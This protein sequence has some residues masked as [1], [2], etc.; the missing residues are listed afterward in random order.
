MNLILFDLDHTLLNG[1]TQSEWGCYLAARGVIDLTAYQA[2]MASFEESYRHGRLNIQEL[3][4]FQLAILKPFPIEQLHAWRE[5]FVQQRIR[6]LIVDAGWKAIAH[7]QEQGD[8]LILITATNEFLTTPIAQLLGIRHLIASKAECDAQGNYT[9]ESC[10]V[11]S[12]REGKITRLHEW[13][14]AEGRS[15]NDYEEIIFYSDSHNDLPLLSLVH[16]PIIVNPDQQL[17]AHAREKNW[18][19]VDFGITRR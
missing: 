14:A 3:V 1:D 13:L 16:R 8:E 9:G 2:K 11:P 19:I 5:E 10:G 18:E 17:L 4:Q 7:H 12:Y 6:P 15:W